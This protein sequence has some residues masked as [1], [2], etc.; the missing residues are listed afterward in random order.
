[1]RGL[2]AYFDLRDGI[3][4]RN[5]DVKTRVRNADGGAVTLDDA[6]FALVDAVDAEPKS[7]KRE[8]GDDAE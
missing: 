1:M 4:V 8:D 5:L 7:N 3:D 6:D 2:L